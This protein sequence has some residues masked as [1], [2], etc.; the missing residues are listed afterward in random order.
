MVIIAPY[1]PYNCFHCE[2]NEHIKPAG[3][4]ISYP[5]LHLYLCRLWTPTA[6]I[7]KSTLKFWLQW[8]WISRCSVKDIHA[9]WSQ[10][11]VHRWNTVDDRCLQ[12]WLWVHIIVWWTKTLVYAISLQLCHHLAGNSHKDGPQQCKY[13]C[14]CTAIYCKLCAVFLECF[15]PLDSSCPWIVPALM[16]AS[17]NSF[18]SCSINGTHHTLVLHLN[19]QSI[20][21]QEALKEIQYYVPRVGNIIIYTEEVGT[22]YVI[23]Y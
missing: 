1:V 21:M 15:L 2:L 13:W 7:P 14:D 8:Q 6:P 22:W 18:K 9:T 17:V 11:C 19:L 16:H 12:V 3:V 10:G 4:Y 5:I 20:Y 23:E